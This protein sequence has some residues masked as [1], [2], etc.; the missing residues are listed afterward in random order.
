MLS[1]S[2]GTHSF[3]KR[4]TNRKR[5]RVQRNQTVQRREEGLE[6]REYRNHQK[7]QRIKKMTKMRTR[8]LEGEKLRNRERGVRL[9]E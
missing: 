1:N 7:R 3:L 6:N 8:N 2:L 9:R 5:R 4:L